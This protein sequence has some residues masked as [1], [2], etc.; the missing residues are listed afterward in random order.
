MISSFLTWGASSMKR[1]LSVGAIAITLAFSN[2]EAQQQSEGGIA[3]AVFPDLYN[4]FDLLRLEGLQFDQKNRIVPLNPNV[5][6]LSG[7]EHEE[8]HSRLR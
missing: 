7:A 3:Q 4:C 5:R 1:L 2:A 6:T 8:G